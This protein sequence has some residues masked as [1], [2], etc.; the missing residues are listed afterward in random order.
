MIETF[1]AFG[2]CLSRVVFPKDSFLQEMGIPRSGDVIAVRINDVNP[3]YPILETTEYKQVKLTSGMRIVGAAGSRWALRG[4]IGV[5]PDS[6]KKGDPINALN[7]GGVLGKCIDYTPELGPATTAEFLGFVATKG[8]PALSAGEE[9]CRKG[10]A[11][12]VNLIQYAPL[13]PRMGSLPPVVAVIGTCMNTGKT[14]A[15][16]AMVKHLSK[17]GLKVA[18]GKI[19]GVAAVKDVKQY[20][21]NGAVEATTFN[22]FGWTSS[23]DITNIVYTS[24]KVIRYL[25]SKDPDIILLELGD[26]IIGKYGVSSLVSSREFRRVISRWV[27]CAYD[28]AGAFG[29]VSY[30]SRY[31]I[32]PAAITGP[33][34]D[35]LAGINAVAEFSAIPVISPLKAPEILARTVVSKLLKIAK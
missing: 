29:A 31:N 18:C 6:L 3:R 10:G 34:A 22:D 8:G 24:T 12:K 15:V 19:C 5:L 32:E 17:D 35:N 7:M 14:T 25:A 28:P 4:F 9:P 27:L 23:A 13:A 20:F 21:K 30:L 11:V 26:G 1:D 33:V 16:S 2:S